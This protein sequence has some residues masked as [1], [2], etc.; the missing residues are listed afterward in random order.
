[1]KKYIAIFLLSLLL[2]A[3][4]TACNK[5]ATKA[6]HSPILSRMGKKSPSP[7]F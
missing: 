7:I 1:M 6:S 2:T 5:K 3:S 4:F